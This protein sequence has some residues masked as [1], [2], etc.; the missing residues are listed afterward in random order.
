MAYIKEIRFAHVGRKEGCLCDRCGQYIQNIVTVEYTDGITT[1]IGQDC[2]KN[3]Y[4]NSK[5]TDFGKKLLRKALK[6]IET[7]SRELAEYTSGK[8]TAE[9]D[10]SWQSYE[11]PW[12]KDCYWAVHHEDYEAYRRWMIEEWFPE[13]FK[14]DQKLIDRF[15]KVNFDR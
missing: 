13:R 14:E 9:T 12:N 11:N 2:F 1:N 10:K 4:D 8:M 7:H 3:L 15:S 6:S 5:L